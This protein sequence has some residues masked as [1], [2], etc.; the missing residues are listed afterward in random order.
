[1]KGAWN[2]AIM[3]VFTSGLLAPD[4]LGHA[5]YASDALK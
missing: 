1:M 4:E 3:V 5:D 2:D